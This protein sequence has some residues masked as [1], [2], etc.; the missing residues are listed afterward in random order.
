MKNHKTPKPH[1][2]AENNS[3]KQLWVNPRSNLKSENRWGERNLSPGTGERFL[4][5]ADIAL[6]LR[7]PH[8][9]KKAVPSVTGAAHTIRKTGPYSA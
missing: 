8:H 1:N 7:K 3:T 4:E 6:G 2:G 9:P 5:L